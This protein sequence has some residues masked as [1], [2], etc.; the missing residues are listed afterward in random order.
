MIKNIYKKC[1]PER[2]RE[3]LKKRWYVY[4]LIWAGG[5]AFVRAA[6]VWLG[7]ISISTFSVGLGW[8][9]VGML[10]LVVW[11]KHDTIKHQARALDWYD[12]FTDQVIKAN[13]HLADGIEEAGG[14]TTGIDVEDKRPEFRR[15]PKD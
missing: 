9:F 13:K 12:S 8:F 6:L 5:D 7:L 15:L 4:L 14:T 3:H 2:V 10:V 1:V 11:I